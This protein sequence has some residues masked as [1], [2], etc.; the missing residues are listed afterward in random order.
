[1]DVDAKKS[2][3]CIPL[4]EASLKIYDNMIKVRS[5]MFSN[6]ARGVCAARLLAV[7]GAYSAPTLHSSHCAAPPR[8]CR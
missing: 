4:D 2:A 1:M 5:R 8:L 6:R 7:L 3:E